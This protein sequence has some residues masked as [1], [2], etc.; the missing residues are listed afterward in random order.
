MKYYLV[1]ANEVETTMMERIQNEGKKPVV[2][3]VEYTFLKFF[4]RVK[5]VTMM[6]PYNWNPKSLK[7]GRE[8]VFPK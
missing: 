3:K 8:I 6:M 5:E 4:K 7:K 2:F 1:E